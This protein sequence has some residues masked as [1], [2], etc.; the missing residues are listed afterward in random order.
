MALDVSAKPAETISDL[1]RQIETVHDGLAAMQSL[2][3]LGLEANAQA[4]CDEQELWKR[5]HALEARLK[6]LEGAQV[7]P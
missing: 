4:R 6:Q 7:K 2:D 3:D 1:R 5:M